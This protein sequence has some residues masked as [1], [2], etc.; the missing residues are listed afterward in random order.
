MLGVLGGIL[1]PTAPAGQDFAPALARIDSLHVARAVDEAAAFIA[2]LLETARAD[3][4]S[5]FI[6][7]L[8][9]KLGRLW[10]S[11]GQPARG[12]PLLREAA[13]LATA[14]RDSLPLHDALRWLGYALEVQGRPA[15]AEAVYRRLLASSLTGGDRRHE[16]WARTG[17][18]FQAQRRG[19][20]DEA[21]QQYRLAVGLFRGLADRQA[22]VWA[23]NG[24][25]TVLQAK[26]AYR[27]AQE[28]YRQVAETGRATGFL[29]V[30]ALAENNL[31]TIE[32]AIGDPG[33]AQ[34][35]FAR[36]EEIQTGLQLWQEALVAGANR[37]LCATYLG[38]FDEA[39]ARYEDLLRTS[40]ERHLPEPEAQLLVLLAGLRQ[41][42]GRPHEAVAS[43]RQLLTDNPADLDLRFRIKGTI[44]LAD[45]LAAVDSV[46]PALNLLRNLETRIAGQVRG[47]QRLELDL[48]L[49]RCLALAGQQEAAL[50]RFTSGSGLADSL[51]LQPRLLSGLAGQ[52]ECLL[53]LDRPDQAL[54]ILRRA[55]LVWDSSRAEPLDREWREAR[56][57]AGRL[58]FSR[59]AALLADEP[60]TA[61][62]TVQSFKART[63]AERMG[64]EKP[65]RVVT[66]AQLQ[67]AVLRPGELLLDYYLGPEESVLFAVTRD[68]LF[69]WRRPA[70]GDLAPRLKTFRDLAATPPSPGMAALPQPDWRPLA[71]LIWGPARPL[72]ADADHVILVPDGLLNL[73]PLCLFDPPNRN[74]TWSRVPSA[75]LLAALRQNTASPTG[76]GILALA[77]TR[78]GSGKQLAGARRETDLLA[79]RFSQVSTGLDSLAQLERFAV[80][81]LASH[82]RVDDQRP[83]ASSIGVDLGDSTLTIQADQ[84]A[85]LA[86]PARLVVLSACSTGGGRTLSGEGVLGLSSAF[87]AAGSA[88]VVASLWPVDDRFTERLMD[89]FYHHL[90]RGRSAAQALARAQHDLRQDPPTAAPFA[91]AGFV[92]IGDG[93]ATVPLHSRRS[94][95]WPVLPLVLGVGAIAL[96]QRRRRR[97]E[98]EKF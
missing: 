30:E 71:D 80:L 49:G 70:A 1:P 9:A 39:A 90:E 63:L 85:E 26:G 88:A 48:A 20:S 47:E 40:R 37:A 66:L 68:S 97:A 7:P 65:F 72:I 91:W 28:I 62:D 69:A 77:G 73:A 35:H 82:A 64:R 32:F 42:Q 2:P 5:A 27:Q 53:A 60:A 33:I 31:G 10:A 21:E 56:G 15:E 87:L 12:E 50:A 81:H 96:L 16:G 4:D 14:R 59:L 76:Q 44:G 78:N 95:L 92:L 67:T 61:F 55:A 45:A 46:A 24:L 75:S 94:A 17:L 86:L 38:R 84:V 13:D 6:L 89:R 83:W 29:M 57:P 51:G 22:E 19:L 23:A 41:Q 93:D 34:Q 98:A 25:A 58:V 3:K 54:A 79:H 74:V 18:G 11:F 52:G 36:A 43:F 8:T